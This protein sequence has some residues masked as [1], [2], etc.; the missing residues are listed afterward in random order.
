MKQ[1]YR[2][3]VYGSLALSLCS[4][5]SDGHYRYQSSYYVNGMKAPTMDLTNPRFYMNDDQPMAPILSN[6]NFEVRQGD[7]EC[8][9]ACG[10]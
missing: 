5:A 7:I 1:P 8:G 6:P 2:I 3:L 9:S 4:C 10:F